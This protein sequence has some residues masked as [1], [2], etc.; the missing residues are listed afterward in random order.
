MREV[1]ILTF[2]NCA[3]HSAILATK[4]ARSSM[5]KLPNKMV[6]MGHLHESGKVSREHLTFLEQTVE[7]NFKFIPVRE[8]PEEATQWRAKALCILKITRP[9]GDLSEEEEAFIV[10]IDNSDWDIP[11]YTHYCLGKSRCVVCSG[12]EVVALM[13]MKDAAELC[14][15]RI[16]PN[17]FYCIGGRA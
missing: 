12:D 15:G 5:E 3:G 7:K 1:R 13:L 17:A 6:R 10:D 8:L 14:A 16:G 2:I 11:W 9:A 4:P